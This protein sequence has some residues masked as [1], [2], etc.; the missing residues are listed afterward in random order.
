MGDDEE[1]EPK[2]RQMRRLGSCRVYSFYLAFFFWMLMYVL[3]LIR[4][5]IF[6]LLHIWRVGDNED[7]KEPNQHRTHCQCPRLV[8]SYFFLCILKTNYC[9]ID[10]SNKRATG[11]PATTETGPNNA[12]RVVWAVGE[13][14]FMFFYIQTT[15]S[16]PLIPNPQDESWCRRW[17]SWAGVLNGSADAY[18]AL[19]RVSFIDFLNIQMLSLR[20]RKLRLSYSRRLDVLK[21]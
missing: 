3:L 19:A 1:K 2:W 11:R 12:R 18:R 4:I 20:R 9:F 21:F 13:F 5:V 7:K 8:Y 17:E 6:I 14:F 16:L 10:S 15:I